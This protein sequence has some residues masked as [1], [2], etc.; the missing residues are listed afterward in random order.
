MMRDLDSYVIAIPDYP[1]PGILFRDVTGILASA[2]GLR[3]AIDQLADRLQDVQFDAIVSME[4]RG[5]IFGMPLAYKLNKA[6][7]PVRKPGKLPRETVSASYELEYGTDTLEMHKDALKPGA[8]VVVVDDLLATGGTA[9]ACARLV[10]C[11]GAKVVKM[12]FVIELEGFA[13]RSGKLAGYEIE[14]LIAYP[15]K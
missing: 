8:R 14:S 3:L 7:V 2:D 5:F 1:K 15:G 10:E 11:L 13:A 4:S 12:L 6:F 9:G